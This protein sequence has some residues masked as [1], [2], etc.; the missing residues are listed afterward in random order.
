MSRSE[1]VKS[2]FDLLLDQIRQVVREEIAAALADKSAKLLLSTNEAAAKLGVED[3][4]SASRARAGLVPCRMLGHYRYFSMSDIEM[5]ID[6][7]GV[8]MVQS[9]HDGKGA[10]TDS[11]APRVKSIP[12]GGDDGNDGD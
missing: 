7:S 9:D 6:T 8:P 3:S 10:S 2:L 11:K 1:P 4:W 5:I 12:T